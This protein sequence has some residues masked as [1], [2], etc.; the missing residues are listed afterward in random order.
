[1]TALPEVLAAW[2][3]PD[4]KTRL[5]AGLEGLGAWG[6]PLQGAL[7]QGCYLS[8]A[9][10]TVSVYQAEEAEGAIEARAAVFFTEIMASCGC[11]GEPMEQNGHCE[12]RVRIDP[13]TGEA[14]IDL[15]DD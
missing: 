12:I 2:P 10:V 5:K 8:D 3:G 13:G 11:G 7:D 4:F 6:L 9:P 15:L 1:M 14:R